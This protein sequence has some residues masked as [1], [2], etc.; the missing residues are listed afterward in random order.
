MNRSSKDNSLKVIDDIISVGVKKGI[1]H[2]NTLNNRLSA[3][4][5]LNLEINGKVISVNSFGSCSYL[6]LEMDE[7]LK[8]ASK[9][10]IDEYGTFFSSSRTYLSCR[11][12]Q[13]LEELL[14]QICGSFPVIL[15]TTTLAHLAALPV[16]IGPNDAVILDHQV[17]NSVAMAV[18]LLKTKGVHTELIR[19]NRTDL[20]E[21]K[22]IK[23][24]QKYK[25]IWYMADGIYSM[26]GDPGPVAAIYNLLNKYPEFHYYA[27]DA[28]GMSCFGKY[29]RGYV[30][31]EKPIH[32]RMIVTV[33]LAK[34]FGTGGAVIIA[35]DKETARMIR[36]CGGPLI[37]SGPLQPAVL[38]AAIASAHIH[39]S[40]EL[41]DLQNELYKKISYTEQLLRESGLPIISHSPSPIFFIG[42]SLPKLGYQLVENMLQKGAYLNLG[43]FPAVPLKNTGIRFT[44]TRLQSDPAI[45]SMIRDLADE[46]QKI[47]LEEGI[48]KDAILKEFRLPIEVPSNEQDSKIKIRIPRLKLEHV[49]SIEQIKKTEWDSLLGS[50]SSYDWEGLSF[51]EKIF[52]GNI[53]PENNWEFDYL[54]IRDLHDRPVVAAPFTTSLCKD[55]MLSSSGISKKAEFLRREDNKYHLTSKVLNSGNLISAG[56]HIYIDHS[57][58]DWQEAVRVLLE[59]LTELQE[60]YDA[61]SILLRDF[62]PG[63]PITEQVFTGNGFIKINLPDNHIIK[64]DWAGGTDDLDELCH[65]SKR[66]KRHIKQ[67]ILRHKHKFD[68]KWVSHLSQVETEHLYNLYLEVNKKS[69]ELNTFRLPYT[70]FEHIL[71]DKRWEVM[72]LTLRPEFD[73]RSEPK[74]VAVTFSYINAKKYHFMFVGL[75]YE[76]QNNHNCYK[77]AIF[78][79]MERASELGMDQLV[80]GYTASQVKSMTFGAEI[81]PAIGYLTIRDNFSMEVL[82]SMNV[83][84]TTVQYKH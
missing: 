62:P 83:M 13:E 64:L 76:Y 30:L 26:F 46:F 35:P 37:T 73:S 1:L 77:Q 34:G 24:K 40:P 71:S 49:K 84:E 3:D 19:H 55:D 42:V 28:H 36:T 75:D 10:A 70:L 82:S 12:Y 66:A 9:K 15:P 65:F 17:H 31:G 4:N 22:I 72:T 39:L 54:I 6:G 47:I 14:S 21:E 56:K 78:L 67:D 18:N 63:D 41:P 16:L 8:N 52:Q 61:N 58:P 27:D 48:T 29:G 53:L 11:H 59:K 50:N 32:E 68:T 43:I 60:S 33:S 80:L 44:I 45:E 79:L 69:F 57:S 74:P 23:L 25:S 51:I 7:R 2:L 38:G 81:V 5:K 20:L